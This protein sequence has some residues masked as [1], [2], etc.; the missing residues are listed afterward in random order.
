MI[1]EPTPLE[2]LLIIEPKCHKDD[3]GFF[4]ESY[5]EDR[6]RES[7]INEKFV[8]GNHSRSKKNNLRGMHFQVKHPQAQIVTVMRGC[9]FDV[10]VDLR[11]NSPTFGE[12]FGAELNDDGPRQIY[13]AAGFAHGFCVLSDVVDLHYKVDQFY[14][15]ADE[16][17]LL[18]NDPYINIHWPVNDP[19]VSIRDNGFPLFKDLQL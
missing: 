11:Q 2:G 10:C 4:M 15:P 3:R 7:G 1:V 9:I 14:N 17:G 8:Q 19:L 5:H 18:W 6:Y 12:W 13:M 16:G